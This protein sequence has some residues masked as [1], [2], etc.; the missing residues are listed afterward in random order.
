MQQTT[1]REQRALGEIGTT[2]VPV[3]A[4]RRSYALEDL[5]FR[6]LA[7]FAAV[8]VLVALAALLGVLTVQAWPALSAFGVRFF[9]TPEWDVVN[10]RFGGLAPVTGTL[11]TSAIAMAI[12]VP[13]AFGAATFITQV[14]PPWFRRPVG[15]AIE[16]LAAVP[17]VI[18]GMWGLFVFAPFFA[19]H[20][21]PLVSS[22]LGRLPL[23]GPFFTG[24][25]IGIGT[26]AAGFVLAIMSLPYI[27]S[28]MRDVF[29]IVPTQLRE[30]AYAMG[31]TTWE[32][33]WNIVLPYTKAGVVSAVILGLGRALGETMA[34]T[35]VVGNSHNLSTSL[36]MP[37]TT[38]SATIAN[39]FAEAST[40]LHQASLI[41]L[42]LL[43][44]V[45]TFTVLTSSKLMLI[46]LERRQG[47]ER[48]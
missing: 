47:G 5:A 19:Q 39:D 17:S 11:V 6:L 16:L 34:V 45:I 27:T 7:Q 38:I 10:D 8:T 35:F 44:F 46:W 24:P 23:I 30:S 33:V 31:S 29:E 2:P 48:T 26:F 13:L 41:A 18:F 40:E 43:L 22:T 25:P 9:I 21:Q 32:V 14:A 4:A 20:V 36:F 12:A 3:R 42:G 28:V 37:G 1:L 15:T